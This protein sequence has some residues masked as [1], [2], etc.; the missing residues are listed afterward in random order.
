M[1]ATSDSASLASRWQSLGLDVA[2]VRVGARGTVVPERTLESARTLPSTRDV[3]LETGGPDVE[4]GR[5]LGEGGMGVVKLARQRTLARDVAV[6]SVRPGGD[7]ARARA[8]LLL[9]ARVTGAL[10]HPNVVP[11]HVVLHDADAEPLIVMK[12]IEGR[13]W[14]ELLA[15]APVGP[16]GRDPAALD[17]H[18]EILVQVARAVH[19][20]HS[21]GVIHRDL[22]PDNVMIGAFGEVYVVDWGIAVSTREDGV[23]GLPLARD[24]REIAGTP[25]YMAPEM[26]A[27]DGA[28]LSPRTDVYLLGAVLH[29]ILTGAPPHEAPTLIARLERAFAS[30]PPVYP[31]AVPPTL[32]AVARRAM[33]F[34]PALR[35]ADAGE[36]VGALQDHARHRAST[37]MSSEAERRLEALEALLAPEPGPGD[38]R[39]AAY[40]GA[41]AERTRAVHAVFGACRFGFAQ[42]LRLWDGNEAA[43]AGLARAL[44]GMIDFEL[45][46]GAPTA[47]E[48][49]LAELAAP[50]PGLVLR[51]RGAVEREA[52]RRAELERVAHDVDTSVGGAAFRAATV[53]ISVAWG[54]GCI[55]LGVLGRHDVFVIGQ[56]GFALVCLTVALS[57]VGIARAARRSLLANAAARRQS[58]TA[59]LI[60][61]LYAALWL[62]APALG[63]DSPATSA[64]AMLAGSALWTTMA[65]LEASWVGLP[66]ALVAGFAAILAWPR[67]NF[68]A[69]GLAS[70]VGGAVSA[71]LR[72]VLTARPP[73]P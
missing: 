59:I 17:R 1:V 47:A 69:M 22:K 70:L 39:D 58:Y 37:L 21:K 42:A 43:R 10:D 7:A 54:L 41:R 18:L 3:A 62:A 12:R 61:L 51:V 67:F 48:S 9:E 11:V 45:A 72:R 66:V 53:A 49:L 31:R 16:E 24:V 57:L 35:Q 44:E 52:A 36:L 19:Y 50:P 13:S 32:A 14:G 65:L 8:Q 4:L 63:L 28:S 33:S 73:G 15:E 23:P 27:G 5:V 2:T 20:A 29:E 60:F 6:K 71:G 34:E 40:T 26:A 64:V 46:R 56:H 25:E 30:E 38:A 55:A 68:E